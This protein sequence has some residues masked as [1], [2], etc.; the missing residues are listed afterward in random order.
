MFKR[1]KHVFTC[2]DVIYLRNRQK[3]FNRISIATNIIFMVGLW[4]VGT[5]VE[6][7][8]TTELDKLLNDNP[9]D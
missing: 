1:N 9:E 2:P 3:K 5:I 8:Q 6:K 4:T 7:R